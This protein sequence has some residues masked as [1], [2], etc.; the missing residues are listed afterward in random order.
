MSFS[1]Q[2]VTFA[3]GDDQLVGVLA[4]PDQPTADL[5]LLIVVGG[6]QYRAGSHRQFVLLA[7]RVAAAGVPVLR[8]DYR[9]MGD[10]TGAV[11]P[12]D[13]TA[14][15]VGAAIAAL[16]V[17]SPGVKRVVLWGLCDA[18]SAVLLYWRATADPR[19]SGMV[20]VN[21]WVRTE[22]TIARAQLKHYYLRR[23]GDRAFWSKLVHGGVD[24]VGAGAAVVRGMV[25]ARRSMAVP[26]ADAETSFQD[27]MADGLRSFDGPVLV[28]LS[29]DDLTAREFVEYTNG[30]PTWQGLL[31][32]DHV[33]RLQIA[34]ADHTFST[35]G[36]RREAETRLIDWLRR[37]LAHGHP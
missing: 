37:T 14:H 29:E 34:G 21:P 15:D 5:A 10:A 2:A 26:A 25:R 35:T 7:R 9:G 4:Q 18:A 36:E 31:D 13:D 24:V 22:A 11:R 19:V 27:R 16:V 12:F 30:S 1:E 3:C 28:V 6:P 20:L 32:R 33:E 17:A 23:L 8:F